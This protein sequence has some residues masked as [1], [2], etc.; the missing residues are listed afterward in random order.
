MLGPGL[1]SQQNAEGGKTRRKTAVTQ[2]TG[3]GAEDAERRGR[4]WDEKNAGWR[5][6]LPT[7]LQFRIPLV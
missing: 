2:S 5:L 3:R 7:A 4:A 1:G 6:A